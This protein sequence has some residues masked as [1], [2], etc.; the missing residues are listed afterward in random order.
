[1][2]KFEIGKKY[3]MGSICEGDCIW[4]YEIVNR[5]NATITIKDEWGNI[6][7]C[8]I[9]KYMSET[10]NVEAV[11]PLGRFSMCPILRASREM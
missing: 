1:M 3:W 11:L 2:K 10:D 5:T 7:K 6:R 4:K 9:N 8:R